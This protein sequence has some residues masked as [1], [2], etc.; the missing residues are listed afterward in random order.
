MFSVNRCFCVFQRHRHTGGI[1]PTHPRERQDSQTGDASPSIL[2]LTLHFCLSLSQE[3]LG[4][5]S[6]FS[7]SLFKLHSNFGRSRFFFFFFPPSLSIWVKLIIARSII[8]TLRVLPTLTLW[9]RNPWLSI[10]SARKQQPEEPSSTRQP[11]NELSLWEETMS[12]AAGG[13]DSRVALFFGCYHY[14][15]L[16]RLRVLLLFLNR[17]KKRK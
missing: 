16:Y 12:P 13:F 10:R 17:F 6:L 7:H 11:S 3:I 1:T 4:C 5:L 14:W 2:N 9:R 8:Q 15:V